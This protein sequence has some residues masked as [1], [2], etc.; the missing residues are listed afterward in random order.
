MAKKAL[1]EDTF[2]LFIKEKKYFLN[3]KMRFEISIHNNGNL[4]L[5]I[6]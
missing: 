5:K 6:N 1:S 4:H 2:L 3:N